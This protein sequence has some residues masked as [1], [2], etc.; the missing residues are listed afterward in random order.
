VLGGGATNFAGAVLRYVH[1]AGVQ[2]IAQQHS[3]CLRIQLISTLNSSTILVSWGNEIPS[4]GF[5][6][7]R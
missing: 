5:E 2:Q 4:Q 3:D 6:I 7:T 1:D